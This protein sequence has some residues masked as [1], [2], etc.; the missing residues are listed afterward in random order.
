MTQ[1]LCEV[2]N[3]LIVERIFLNLICTVAYRNISIQRGKPES[4][5]IEPMNTN[6]APGPPGLG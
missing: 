1:N 4:L 3:N 2:G 5:R 6:N